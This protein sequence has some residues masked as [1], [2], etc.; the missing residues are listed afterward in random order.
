MHFGLIADRT[1]ISQPRRV[2]NR[3]AGAL[4]ALESA[5]AG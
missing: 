3:V 1:L 4:A 2:V 5:V